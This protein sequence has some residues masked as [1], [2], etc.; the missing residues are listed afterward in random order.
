[1]LFVFAFF[2]FIFIIIFLKSWK[3]AL[4]GLF[5]VFDIL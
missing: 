1:M 5:R 4:L 2:I 3:Y